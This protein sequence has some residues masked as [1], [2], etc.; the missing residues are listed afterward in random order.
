M[1]AR[2]GLAREGIS[3]PPVNAAEVGCGGVG[4]C[5]GGGGEGDCE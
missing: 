1:W 2:A 3:V 4:E 5:V